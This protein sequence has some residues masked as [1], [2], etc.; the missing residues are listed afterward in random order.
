LNIKIDS[1]LQIICCFLSLHPA[2][3]QK[4]R[5]HR[6]LSLRIRAFALALEACNA[7]GRKL[8]DVSALAPGEILFDMC[9]IHM[10]SGLVSADEHLDCS[11]RLRMQRIAP[12]QPEGSIL[13]V[14][15]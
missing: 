5:V 8:A 4:I 10:P 11:P 15:H 1:D 12:V 2:D 3:A 9:H 13:V 7:Y 14:V 6:E